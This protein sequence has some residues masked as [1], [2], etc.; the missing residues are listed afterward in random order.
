MEKRSS[1]FGDIIMQFLWETSYVLCTYKWHGKHSSL[2][3]MIPLSM[4]HVISSILQVQD[5]IT[6]HEAYK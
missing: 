4:L 3:A 6:K 5:E 1:F 2:R